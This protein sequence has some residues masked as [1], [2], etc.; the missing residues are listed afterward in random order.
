MDFD[1]R[2]IFSPRRSWR[3]ERVGQ[4]LLLVD[5]MRSSSIIYIAFL[6]L[7]SPQRSFGQNPTS[8][9]LKLKPNTILLE[10]DVCKTEKELRTWAEETYGMAQFLFGEKD[11]LPFIVIFL[12]TGST[13]PPNRLVFVYLFDAS[14]NVWRPKVT[15]FTTEVG[16]KCEYRKK[17]KE[18]IFSSKGKKH[19][20]KVS[21]ASIGLRG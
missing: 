11:S 17:S 10:L 19:L 4:L 1:F 14:Q 8:Y 9:S 15:W 2:Q 5:F 3:P 18:L 13:A 6:L 12:T 20:I 7:L 21:L 16:L